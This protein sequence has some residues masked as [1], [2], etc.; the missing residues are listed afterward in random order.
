M[1]RVEYQ[2]QIYDCIYE[3]FKI[4]QYNISVFIF[5]TKYQQKSFLLQLS[6]KLYSK[7]Q[8]MMQ[9]ILNLNIL[10][11]NLINSISL[12]N[13]TFNQ[14]YFNNLNHQSIQQSKTKFNF[15]YNQINNIQ[16]NHNNNKQHQFNLHLLNLIQN[17]FTYQIIK[18]NKI[19]Q[20][21]FC[22]VIAINQDNSIVAVGCNSQISIY[23]F[24][25][26]MMKQIQILN[27]HIGDVFTLKFMIKSKQLISGDN[28]GSIVI[29]SSY[30]NNQWNFSQT[31]QGH[32]NQ[33][34][35]L[36]LNTNEDLFISSNS[37]SSIKFWM[38]QNEWIRQQKITVHNSYAYQLSL[39]E[40]QDKVI[41]CRYDN[42]ILLEN[43]NNYDDYSHKYKQINKQQ[44]IFCIQIIY[45]KR[46]IFFNFC[47]LQQNFRSENLIALTNAKSEVAV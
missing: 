24:K 5:N 28:G 16:I 13:P 41:S 19:K 30:D 20:D 46:D 1:I 34:L 47:N 38:K 2:I 4:R 33:I 25:Q 44:L 21:Q 43:I 23:E 22:F 39:N 8:R 37:D 17:L 11:Q 18:D 9:I 35:C 27:Q 29:W 3:N 42:R 15:N 45:E 6:Q 7:D 14:R 31:I 36:I 12:V 10:C 40:Q 32:R 26:G